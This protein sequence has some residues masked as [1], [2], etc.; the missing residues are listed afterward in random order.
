LDL[1]ESFGVIGILQMTTKV[2]IR[3]VKLHK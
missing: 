2:D 3:T 1:D